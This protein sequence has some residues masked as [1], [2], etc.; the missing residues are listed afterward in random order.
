MKRKFFPLF[1]ALV[2][3]LLPS[4]ALAEEAPPAQV[5]QVETVAGTGTHGALNGAAMAQFNLPLSLT[6]DGNNLYIAD[7]YNNLI[8]VINKDGVTKTLAGVIQRQDVLRFPAGGYRDGQLRRARF[9]RPGG[10]VRVGGSRMFVTDTDNHAIRTVDRTRVTTY[11]GGESGYADGSLSEAKFNAPTGIAVD[12]KNN[13]YIADTLNHCI[14]KID[15]KGNVTTVAG[16]PEESGLLDGKAGTAMFNSPMGIAV[17]EDG[18]EIYVADTGNHRIR[19]IKNGNVSTYAG[20]TDLVDMDGEPWGDFLDGPNKTAKFNLP[21]GLA[22]YNGN[23]IVADSGN[24]RIR[25]VT[26]KDVTTIAGTGEPGDADGALLEASFSL[27]SGV[28]VLDDILFVADTG[29]NLIR[30]LPLK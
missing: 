18:K 29:N 21:I 1:M 7:T 25:L 13:V 6:G 4:A 30:K 2:I 8:R 15:A 12:G 20:V 24:N 23:L 11:T 5:P 16:T 3:I 28:F 9:N 14:R 19:L 22:L 17:T 27:P 10:M 26:E